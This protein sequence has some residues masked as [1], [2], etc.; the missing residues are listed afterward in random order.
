MHQRRELCQPSRIVVVQVASHWDVIKV[1]LNSSSI[2][3]PSKCYT[4]VYGAVA[5]ASVTTVHAPSIISALDTQVMAVPR[6]W[7][8][9]T[10]PGAIPRGR[11]DG[12]NH[13]PG[14]YSTSCAVARVVRSTR[15]FGYFSLATNGDVSG[16]PVVV[17]TLPKTS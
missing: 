8:H 16:V 2:Y 3:R 15:M 10:D 12:P 9:V 14:D 7:P 6:C 1:R 13:L 5:Q 17:S 11:V 4:T